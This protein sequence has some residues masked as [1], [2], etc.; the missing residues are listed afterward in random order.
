MKRNVIVVATVAIAIVASAAAY[1]LLTQGPSFTISANPSTLTLQRGGSDNVTLS[2]NPDVPSNL[3][4]NS[5][6]SG[7]GPGV[8]V[9]GIIDSPFTI[10]VSV[11]EN[12]ALGTYTITL[13]ATDGD[14]GAVATATVTLTVS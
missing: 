1:F 4:M 9:D 5:S 3:G 13:E 6:V 11:S 14:T 2:Y 10:S 12:A 8:Q 7:P